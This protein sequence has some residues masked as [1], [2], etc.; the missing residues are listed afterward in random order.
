[1]QGKLYETIKLYT[2]KVLLTTKVKNIFL[3]T[4]ILFSPLNFNE[5]GSFDMKIYLNDANLIYKSFNLSAYCYC[6]TII[7]Y[8]FMTTINKNFILRNTCFF[9]L[10][11]KIYC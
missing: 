5:E 9:E 4:T 11:T 2:Q 3:E 7:E 10:L 6:T 8:L 1:M